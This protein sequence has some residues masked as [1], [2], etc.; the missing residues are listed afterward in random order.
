M[1][2]TRKT[3]R[4]EPCINAQL[5]DEDFGTH[6]MRTVYVRASLLE[7]GITSKSRKMLALGYFCFKCREFW[8]IEQVNESFK[9][10]LAKSGHSHTQNGPNSTLNS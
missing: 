10:M 7:E 8:T 4:A 1:W 6:I 5:D 3:G 9:N 2:K